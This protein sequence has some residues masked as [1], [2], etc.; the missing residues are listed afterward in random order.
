MKRWNILSTVG[1]VVVA[2]LGCALAS[3]MFASRGT[4]MSPLR[5][6][7]FAVIALCVGLLTSA[8][9]TEIGLRF[10]SQWID[11]T[12][13]SASMGLRLSILLCFVLVILLLATSQALNI[14]VR[15]GATVLLLAV[16]AETWSIVRF[17]RKVAA[18]GKTAK[19]WIR[20]DGLYQYES[21]VPG[22]GLHGDKGQ[23]NYSPCF[24]FY[25]NGKVHRV[26][27]ATLPGQNVTSWP[28]RFSHEDSE[29]LYQGKWIYLGWRTIQTLEYKFDRS[30]IEITVDDPLSSKK[31]IYRGHLNSTGL[32]VL[33]EFGDLTKM[34]VRTEH[35][36][37]V[38]LDFSQGRSSQVEPVGS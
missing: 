6:A 26:S 15:L 23:L 10:D 9:N 22:E 24:R 16:V 13:K 34:H 3:Y 35:Y 18:Q 37:F 5:I 11:V 19:A 20:F 29:G 17:L 8:S 14:L 2:V 30:L 36:R 25:S 31:D 21:T 12:L 32:L 38:K 1:T 33:E 7:D 27:F 28:Y 4:A